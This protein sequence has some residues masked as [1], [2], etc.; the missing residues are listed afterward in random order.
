MKKIFLSFTLLLSTL[1]FAQERKGLPPSSGKLKVVVGLS[2]A[3]KMKI[4]TLQQLVEK[5][6]NDAVAVLDNSKVVYKE[7]EYPVY[8]FNKRTKEYNLM[9][10]K[11]VNQIKIE[12]IKSFKYSKDSSDVVLF[13]SRVETTGMVWIELK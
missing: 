13:G 8:V 7:G 1:S 2:D 6:Y 4:P 9:E 12:D 10:S 3:E 11:D 5:M